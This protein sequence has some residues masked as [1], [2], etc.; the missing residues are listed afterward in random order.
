MAEPDAPPTRPEDTSLSV[1]R[2]VERRVAAGEIIFE[3]GEPGDT[4][5]VVQMGEVEISRPTPAGSHRLARL[6]PGDFFGEMSVLVG[7]PRRA[8]ATAVGETQVL[9]IDALTL[10]NMCMDRPEIAI[11][12]IQ[13]LAGRLVD[14]EQ[15][16]AALGVE[17][18]LRPVVR[19]LLRRAERTESG[20]RI[21]TTL[22]RIS[23]EAGLTLLETHRALQQLFD[24][25]L[26]RL[27][28]DVL[29]IPDL[30]AL[31]SSLE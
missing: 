3:V 15:R 17:D 28:E 5:F 13:R 25:R 10:Q 2:A 21:A 1:R 14:L 7:C 9:E 6:G 19:V 27:C 11:R 26:V 8:R 22:R 24:G 29:H 12:I 31:S 30:E 20:A 23:A 18:L 4:L 16:L